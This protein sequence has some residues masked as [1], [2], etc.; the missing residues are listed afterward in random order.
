MTTLN[1]VKSEIEKELNIYAAK[2]ETTVKELFFGDEILIFFNEP[3]LEFSFENGYVIYSDEPNTK[4]SIGKQ[5]T[6]S[7]KTPKGYISSKKINVSVKNTSDVSI[8]EATELLK[9]NTDAVKNNFDPFYRENQ[10]K[11]RNASAWNFIASNYLQ[12]DCR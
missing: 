8:E 3:T 9:F 4:E 11:A 2:Y 12:G 6:C 7:F 10:A 1:F 5:F